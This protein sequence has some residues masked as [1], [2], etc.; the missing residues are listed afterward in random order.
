[1][2]ENKAQDVEIQ[3][4][5]AGKVTFNNDVIATIAALATVDVPGVAGM[6]GGFTSGVA[7]LLGRKN[8]TK[9]V[10][11]EVGTTECAVDLNLV[12]RYGAKIHEVCAKIQEEVCNAIETMTG[13]KVVEVNVHVQGVE[14]EKEKRDADALSAPKMGEVAAGTE[15]TPRVR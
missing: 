6:S 15:S 9:G 13:L 11:V 10:K 14:I 8:L 1:M 2:A 5:K 4:D 12:I 7:E 3:A